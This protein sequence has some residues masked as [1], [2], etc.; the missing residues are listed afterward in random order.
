MLT[1]TAADFDPN[2]KTVTLTYIWTNNGQTVQTTTTTSTTDTLD[3]SKAGNGDKGDLI[4][5][6]VTPNNG[7]LDGPTKS[8]STT[9]V[10]SPP[11]V[12]VSLAPEHLD[13]SDG[14]PVCHRHRQQLR[15]RRRSGHAHLHL[16]GQ[17]RS[18]LSPTDAGSHDRSN[19]H[20]VA[21]RH[22]PQGDVVSVQ[23][24]PYD[25][26]ISGTAATDQVTVADS[27]PVAQNATASVGHNNTAGVDIT[28]VAT[29]A[30]G[31]PLTYS[32]TNNGGALY[33]TVSLISNN[34]AL[35]IPNTPGVVK[36]DSFQW[37]ASDGTLSTSPAGVETVNLTNSP[38]VAINASYDVVMNNPLTIAAP[39]V[40]TGAS[41]ADLDP[42]TAVVISQPSH[43]TLTPDANGDGG[44]MYNPNM[45]FTGDDS[46][47]FAANDG[48]TNGNTATVFL[49][50]TDTPP[51]ANADAYTVLENTPLTTTTSNGLLSNDTDSNHVALQAQLDSTPLHGILNFNANGSFTY[52][53]TTGYV[54]P[55]S[56]TYHNFD[57]TLQSNT[58]TVSL[59][60]TSN[61]PPPV[62]NN[63][64]YPN[65]VKNNALSIAAPGVL[66]ND[67]GTGTLTAL[68]DPAPSG[69][70]NTETLPSGATVTLN[71]NGSFVY[72]P[73]TGFTGSDTFTYKVVDGVGDSSLTDATVTIDVN[74]VAPVATSPP[75]AYT[76]GRNGTL[77]VSGPG[78][79]NFAHDTDN[80]PLK[81]SEGSTG[82]SHGTLTVDPTGDGGFV[83]TPTPGDTYVGPDTFTFVANDGSLTSNQA[84]VTINI[85]N[86]PPVASSFNYSI[87][88]NGTPTITAAN[89]TNSVTDPNNE[90]LTF[91]QVI[92][93]GHPNAQNGMVTVN[94]NGT[95]VYTP[96]A[97]FA[98]QDSFTYKA[99]DGAADSNTATVF[100]N[101]VNTPPVAVS[102]RRP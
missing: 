82:P 64:T 34:V 8:T 100:I 85:T 3:L 25:G 58:T 7:S 27:A 75:T 50:D 29:D 40:L 71:A 45:G 92:D 90:V 18:A 55:D 10:N 69:G 68:L 78:L 97:G 30:D 93:S 31:D 79:L 62:A 81:I 6:S 61:Q 9:V 98:G 57:G 20:A 83:Y 12:T 94:P 88:R 60:V 73:M 84:T 70:G 56:F 46:F 32:I 95:F 59:T 16:A 96:T 33:G 21:C 13:E 53:P 41:D 15:R 86:T 28:L 43:G 65:V 42:L 54:G 77:T 74:A 24:I 23:V 66:G 52:T 91:S 63:D 67:T 22:R 48:F 39:G 76:V 101:V 51:V 89:L 99:N 72:T 19:R 11:T 87:G 1:A 2:G 37:T 44:F 5:V 35:Y 26:T 49:D 47:T 17:R 4:A 102:P 80:D 36:A 38:P 14:H